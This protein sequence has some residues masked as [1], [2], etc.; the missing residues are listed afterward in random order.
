LNI[1]QSGTKSKG[2]DGQLQNTC[3]D[4]PK[5]ERILSSET[6]LPDL[7]ESEL[8]RG[9]NWKHY[10]GTQ[11][12]IKKKKIKWQLSFRQQTFSRKEKLQIPDVLSRA[13]FLLKVLL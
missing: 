11:L 7:K 2:Y 6:P 3:Q 10:L 5:I 9:V 1:N 8:D 13:Y 4:L 12:E